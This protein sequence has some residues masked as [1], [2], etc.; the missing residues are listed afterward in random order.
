[1]TT[2]FTSLT[3]LTNRRNTDEIAIV[4]G[5]DTR[6]APL[7]VVA[8]DTPVHI[9]TPELSDY[10]SHSVVTVAALDFRADG[11][12]VT[13]VADYLAVWTTLFQT[14]EVYGSSLYTDG[15]GKTTIHWIF[16][17]ATALDRQYAALLMSGDEII[18]THTEDNGDDVLRVEQVTNDVAGERVILRAIL[19]QENEAGFGDTGITSVAVRLASGVV[20]VLVRT[21]R[22]GRVVTTPV[23]SREALQVDGL[24]EDYFRSLK[25]RPVVIDKDG[26]GN[27]RFTYDA[28]NVLTVVRG[29]GTTAFRA[30]DGRMK[31][32]TV[33]GGVTTITYHDAILGGGGIETRN[34]HSGERREFAYPALEETFGTLTRSVAA[35]SQ[36]TDFMFG[37]STWSALINGT[38]G[39]TYD[40][41]LTTA[42]ASG[43]SVTTV[44]RV[45]IVS[46]S[47]T[48][49]PP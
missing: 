40:A 37:T 8:P 38:L 39:E 26:D 16:S 3:A 49:D 48:L 11:F 23:T 19:L 10:E 6:R 21:L 45:T 4:R 20:G 44:Y 33:N 36:I 22:G 34:G 9:S 12:S 15:A 46:S 28:L 35:A 7:A 42:D 29:A 43:R 30:S 41:T 24:T 18:V 5:A 13:S 27:T 47:T 1:M 2:A 25:D 14:D 31:G 32:I 17:V